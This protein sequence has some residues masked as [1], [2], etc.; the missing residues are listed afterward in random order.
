MGLVLGGG[1]GL[2]FFKTFVGRGG[3]AIRLEEGFTKGFVV[4]TG[5]LGRMVGFVGGF[6]LLL[7][8]GG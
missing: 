1:L 7:L 5:L 3:G 8:G 2:F 4:G 6:G